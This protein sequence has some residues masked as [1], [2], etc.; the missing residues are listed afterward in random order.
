MP[1]E[2]ENTELLRRFG[3]RCRALRREKGFSQLDMVREFGFSLSH[4]QKIE[5]GVLD[6]RLSTLT[7]IASSFGTS[8]SGL[9]EGVD[10]L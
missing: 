4:Y 1:G 8:L 3:E 7:R 9:F 6:P 5:R 10:D 2:L